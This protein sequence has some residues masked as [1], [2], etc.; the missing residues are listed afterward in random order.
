LKS[1]TTRRFR[2]AYAELPE[3][4]RRQARRAYRTF[5]KNPLHPGLNFKKLDGAGEIYSVRIGISYRALAKSEGAELVW[6]WIGPHAEYDRL[7]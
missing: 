5:R 1:V 7:V 3:D 2:E 4:V 6:F